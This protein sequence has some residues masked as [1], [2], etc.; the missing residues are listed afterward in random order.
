MNLFVD[1]CRRG[2]LEEVKRLLASYPQFIEYI[3]PALVWACYYGHLE[4]VK[5]LLD[6]GANVHINDE[7]AMVWVISFEHLDVAKL[8]VEYGADLSIV[9]R[10]NNSGPV[11]DYLNKQLLIKKIN[12]LTNRSK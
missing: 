5:F 4:I 6:N 11:I 9:E 12:E 7:Q 8:L 3:N 2:N 10:I 1:I